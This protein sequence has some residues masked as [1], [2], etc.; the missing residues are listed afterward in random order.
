MKN[1]NAFIKILYI[2][3]YIALSTLLITTLYVVFIDINPNVILKATLTLDVVLII[4]LT[5]SIR[6][7]TLFKKIIFTCIVLY[8]IMLIFI[9]VDYLYVKIPNYSGYAKGK[10]INIYQFIKYDLEWSVEHDS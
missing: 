2:L 10:S 7:P 4:I 6:K 8:L 5:I 9:P 1:I 3:F